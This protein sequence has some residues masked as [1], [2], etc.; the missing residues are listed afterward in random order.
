MGLLALNFR[1]ATQHHSYDW[2]LAI[3]RVNDMQMQVTK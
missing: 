2:P 1:A 3:P